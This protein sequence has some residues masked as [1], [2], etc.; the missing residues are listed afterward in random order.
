MHI[1]LI[2]TVLLLLTPFLLLSVLPFYISALC[3]CVVKIFASLLE[4]RIDRFVEE[5]HER[6]T[7]SR[8]NRPRIVFANTIIAPNHRLEKA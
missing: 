4:E 7:T 3:G 5:Q 8:I 6:R 2:R 1:H